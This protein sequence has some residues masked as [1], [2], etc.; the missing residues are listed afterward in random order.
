MCIAASKLAR[1]RSQ[2]VAA[3]ASQPADNASCTAAVSAGVGIR[4]R[5]E[6]SCSDYLPWVAAAVNRPAVY[7]SR[8]DLA[9]GDEDRDVCDFDRSRRHDA[10]LGAQRGVAVV[11]QAGVAEEAFD[12]V[13]G[14][15]EPDVGVFGAHPLV[16]MLDFVG[17]RDPAS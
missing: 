16:G 13:A 9:P 7:E 8:G 1:A 2:S 15:A 10:S 4:W 3:S 5:K 12:L 11:L 6:R 17:D 14:E